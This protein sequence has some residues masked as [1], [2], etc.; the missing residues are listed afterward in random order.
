MNIKYDLIPDTDKFYRVTVNGD[1]LGE[2]R[3]VYF[4]TSSHG[5]MILPDGYVQVAKSRLCYNTRKEATAALIDFLRNP[6]KRSLVE[7]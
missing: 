1:F 3:K 2:V 4:G 7:G 6:H 5:W